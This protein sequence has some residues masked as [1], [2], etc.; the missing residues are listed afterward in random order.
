MSYSDYIRYNLASDV[1]I[2][3]NVC[4]NDFYAERVCRTFSIIYG[5]RVC[6]FCKHMLWVNGCNLRELSRLY[7]FVV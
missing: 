4:S 1:D 3:L 6:R 5:I 2:Y 7:E